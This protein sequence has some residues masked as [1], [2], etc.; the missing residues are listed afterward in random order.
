MEVKRYAF[1]RKRIGTDLQQI[2]TCRKRRKILL[3]RVRKPGDQKSI[4]NFVRKRT[5]IQSRGG[6]GKRLRKERVKREAHSLE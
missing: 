2:W 4:P 3:R 5:A 6:K 1:T